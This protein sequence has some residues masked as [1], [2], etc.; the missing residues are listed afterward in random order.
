MHHGVLSVASEGLGCGSVFTME[1]PAYVK[2]LLTPERRPRTHSGNGPN[3][4][5]RN[6][7]RAQFAILNIVTAYDSRT[8]QSDSG[9]ASTDI[10]QKKRKV[11]P[12]MS[13]V[14]IFFVL[15]RYRNCLF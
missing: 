13:E 10:T 6:E 9:S 4:I 8:R 1:L 12:V 5:S 2:A 11:D 3:V 15:L 14:C 7:S